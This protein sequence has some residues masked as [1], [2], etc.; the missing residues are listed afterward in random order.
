[1]GICSADEKTGRGKCPTAR[2]LS[3]RTAYSSFERLCVVIPFAVMSGISRRLLARS[4]LMSAGVVRY[5][6]S[7]PLAASAEAW[8]ELAE[9]Y[10]SD[11]RA[12]VACWRL[13]QV[14][15]GQ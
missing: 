11:P 14:A 3:L 2:L 8:G 7:Y 6:D 9:T 5:Y 15:L 10:P 13:A 12:G 1:M 4:R